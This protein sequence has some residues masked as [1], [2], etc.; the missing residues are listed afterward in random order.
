MPFNQGGPVTDYK[1]DVGEGWHSLL[2][3]M[4]EALV[5]ADPSYQTIQ[6]KEKF[7]G[8]RV[9]INANREAQDICGQFEERSHHICEVCGKPGESD[10]SHFWVKTL[11]PDHKAARDEDYRK[12]RAEQGEK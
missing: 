8:L 6:V 10:A 4:H 1:S 3:E 7:A 12:L 5:K 11:C 9:Y 2:D